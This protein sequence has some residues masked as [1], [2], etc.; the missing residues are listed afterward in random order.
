[1]EPA[2]FAS[3]RDLVRRGL[4]LMTPP[5]RRRAGWLVIASTSVEMLDA[6]S[7]LAVVAAVGLVVQ[8]DLLTSSRTLAHLRHVFGQVDQNTLMIGVAA[9]AMVL[10]IARTLATWLLTR[11]IY[12]FC[13]ACK[14]RLSH[15]L[16]AEVLD[17]PYPWFL[18]RNE[19][20]LAHL[21]HEDAMAWG[22]VFVERTLTIAA[23]IITAA[24]SAA[25]VLGTAPWLGL[26]TLF[27]VGGLA[28]A[29]AQGLRPRLSKL[30]DARH[31]ALETLALTAT[32]MLAGIKDVKLASATGY[33]QELFDRSHNRATSTYAYLAAWHQAP[34]LILNLF[35]QLVLVTLAVGLAVT[36]HTSGYIALNLAML[37][38]VTSRLAPAVSN[39]VTALSTIVQVGP[40]L[41]RIEEVR[42]SV[43]AARAAAG[44]QP[45]PAPWD[46][47][48]RR[49]ELDAVTYRYDGAA[50]PAVRDV[51]F[52][53]ERGQALGLAGRSGAGKSTLVD[54]LLMLLAPTG[55]AVRVDGRPLA[56]L[57]AG[58]WQARIGYV[59]QAPY[60]LDDTLRANVAF[61]VPADKIDEARVRECLRHASLESFVAELPR[62][63]ET[64]LGDRGT[65]LSGGQR[66]RVAIARALYRR[67]DL[68]VLD[69]ATSGLDQI[70][71]SAVRDTVDHLR[72]QVTTITI[73]HQLGTLATCDRIVLLDGG[74][75]VATGT[76]A[77]L[78]ERCALYR[79]LGPNA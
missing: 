48:W 7:V 78:S 61:G 20:L 72:G 12:L 50:Q 33:F 46:G 54:I 41:A 36:G 30:S 74:A 47:A 73:A 21:F 26:I 60:L 16:L 4:A 59:P 5:E 13:S 37:A 19:A 1:M 79:Q 77:E 65:R 75:V 14:D 56:T 66:Q 70:T 22:R 8:R 28:L 58:V 38:L 6:V 49:L 10:R 40:S 69:E 34:G 45:A 71:S 53:L 31:A 42:G 3:F 55:G 39:L 44:G 25:L 64:P 63:L 51:T 17:A 18:Q 11:A 27:A 2:G 35:G 62:G 15:D 24:M 23:C 43:A 29:I 57:G 67:P 68:L 32:H 9:A 76:H 52:A